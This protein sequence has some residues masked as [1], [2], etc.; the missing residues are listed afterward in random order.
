[1]AVSKVVRLGDGSVTRVNG[2][3]AINTKLEAERA[4]V[5]RVLRPVIAPAVEE[6]PTFS[7][8]WRRSGGRRIRRLRAIGIR[9]YARKKCIY[10]AT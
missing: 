2:T 4:H 9:R 6:V 7:E 3:P 5:E 1:M 10:V 8:S